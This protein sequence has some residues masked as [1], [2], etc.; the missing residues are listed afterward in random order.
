LAARAPGCYVRVNAEIRDMATGVH[1][2]R[3]TVVRTKLALAG[4][5]TAGLLMAGLT[6]ATPAYAASVPADCTVQYQ[7]FSVSM[8]CTARPATQVWNLA[9]TCEVLT[10]GHLRLP[11][12]GS[13]VTGDGTSNS[14]S[15]PN[16]GAVT[17][18]IDS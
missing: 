12:S 16:P 8:T 14:G 11:H 7:E 9:T 5:A 17:F 4:I 1:H 10:A 6:I 13:E 15:C 2:R 18:V 3:D